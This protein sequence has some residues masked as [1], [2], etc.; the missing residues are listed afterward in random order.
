MPMSKDFEERLFLILPKIIEDFGTPFHIY[1]ESG[2]IRTGEE[3]KKLF[4]GVSG[5]QEFFAIK[6]NPNLEILKIMKRLEFG[7]DCSSEPE[8]F[9]ARYVGDG[10]TVDNIIFS[11]NN[12][13]S[14]EFEVA[15]RF[16]GCILNL[17]DIS[18]VSKVPG[19]FP[20]TIC[21]RYN[22]GK[23]RT[24]NTII[25]EP[26]DSK[27]GIRHDQIVDAYRI[28]IKRGA[29]R[30]GLHTMICSNQLDYTYM[31]ETIK[32]LLGIVEMVSEELNIKFKFINV[33]GGIGIPYKPDGKLFNMLAFAKEAKNLLDQ[34][35]KKYGYVPD[36]FMESGR[37]MTGPHGVLVTKVI[38]VMEKYKKFIGVDASC[39]STMM[40]PAIY[41]PNGGYHH[42]SVFGKDDG[43]FEIVNIV[44]S[45]CENNDQFGWNRKL[46]K[47]REDD[48]VIIH[49]TGAH[50][51]GMTSNYNGRLRPQELMLR[52]DG[53]VE[54]IRQAENLADYLRTLNN[55]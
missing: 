46:P 19:E 6:A 38:N 11:S 54:K 22:P 30:F 34:F 26:E 44:G 5:F 51:Y 36:F 4:S 12:T 3:L 49:D 42:I 24:G 21:F 31:V 23:R 48:I 7:F 9:L 20:E 32:M 2:V 39:I 47:I 53:G 41:Y 29:K 15:S 17:D 8:L 16:G 28:A 33:G 18:M 50:C 10:V 13:S 45:A 14:K 35:K 25:G 40:R 1:D 37:Y 43:P 55:V 27:Y 52:S